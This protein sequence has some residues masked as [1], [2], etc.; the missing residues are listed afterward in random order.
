MELV[1]PGGRVVYSTCTYAPEENEGVL[2]V[3]PEDSAVIEPIGL[4][5][6]LTTMAGITEW[7]GRTYREDVAHA[8]RLWPHQN[9]T[10]GFF[11]ACIRRL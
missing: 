10:G 7:Q 4:P 6:G 1:R 11:V 8:I 9:N 2:D 3:L 5:T